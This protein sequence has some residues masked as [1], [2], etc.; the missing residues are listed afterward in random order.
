[1]NLLLVFFI[2]MYLIFL[3]KINIDAGCKFFMSILK[4]W[5]VNTKNFVCLPL[6]KNLLFFNLHGLL[7]DTIL[8]T[9]I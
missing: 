8:L 6:I 1:M 9:E 2:Q 7:F 4:S 3:S 5:D